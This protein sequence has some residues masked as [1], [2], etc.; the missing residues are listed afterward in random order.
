M[1]SLLFL[2][3]F[4][5]FIWW[6]LKKTSN[7]PNDA[8]DTNSN[9]YMHGY[10]DGYQARQTELDKGEKDPK[11][12]GMPDKMR[13]IPTAAILNMAESHQQ[14]VQYRPPV[15]NVT[16]PHITPH[17]VASTHVATPQVV[18]HSAAPVKSS[19]DQAAEKKKRDLQNINTTLYVASFLLVAA[20]A[21]FVAVADISASIRF[22]G[23]W[24][25]TIAFYSAGLI[26][27]GTVPRLRPAAI[28]FA[29][30]GLAL[31]PFTG[32]AMYNFILPNAPLSWFVTSLISLAAFI[33]A[34]TRLKNEV[35]SYL[36][37]AFGISLST[38]G[39]AVLD[40][41]LIWYYVVL[42]L[43]GS[44]LTI[45][46][47]AR[48]K[49][50]PDYFASPIQK[51]NHWIV[52]LTIISSIF[53]VNSLTVTD[54]WIIS[55]A[56]TLYY[57]AVAA[58][59]TTTRDI[60]IFVVRL[61]ASLTVILMAYDLSD[62]SWTV[63]GL[64]IAFVGLLQTLV[65]ILF[66]PH[67]KA[68]E[69]NNEIWL[70]IGFGMQ[71]LSVLFI[72]NDSSWNTVVSIQ[73]SMMLASSLGIAYWL[74]RINLS[75]FGTISLVSLPVI[76]ER[77]I[78]QPPLENQW[79]ALTFIAF[80]A[81]LLAI[82]YAKQII[83]KSPSLI[84]YIFVN[85]S[86]FI[87][88][89]LLFTSGNISAGWGFTIWSVATLLVYGLMYIES[90]PWLSIVANGMIWVSIVNFI[91]PSVDAQWVA[92]IF[93][94]LASIALVLLY[95]DKYIEDSKKAI[96]RPFIVAN[97]TLF[98][99]QSLIFTVGIP[100]GWGFAIWSVA[101]LLVYGLMYLERQPWLSIVANG[102]IFVSI[103]TYIKPDLASH[104]IAFIFITLATITF[105]LLVYEKQ[106]KSSIIIRPYII[107]N[108]VLFIAQSL[109]FTIN[110]PAGWGF[111]I[112]SVA[113]VL[114]YGLM[115]LER[116][117]WLSIV[118][119]GMIWFSIVSFIKPSIDD[120]WVALIFIILASIALGILYLEKYIEDSKKATFRPF[121]VANI[122]L[123]II[124]SLMFTVS[125][126]AIWGLA[127]WSI[128][129]A[130]VYGVMYLESKPWVS[131]VA[132][133]MI[134][135]LVMQFVRPSI[136]FHWLAVIFI[137]LATIAFGILSVEK[138]IN[139]NKDLGIRQYI[140]AN[141]A[142]F[143][144][145]S[146]MFTIGIESGWGLAVWTVATAIVYGV[147]Y[148][149]RQPWL[150]ILAN[151][152]IWIAVTQFIQP[153]VEVYWV[154]LIFMT[155]SAISLGLLSLEKLIF[156]NAPSSTRQSIVVNFLLF[157]F[158]SLFLTYGMDHNWG[159]GLW[160]VAT[161]FAYI[162]VYL[163][164]Q[165]WLILI[166][167]GMLLVSTSRLLNIMDIATEWKS[168]AISWVAF[169]VFY[170]IYWILKLLSQDK[171]AVYQWWSAVVVAGLINILSLTAQSHDVAIMAG[172]GL[173]I[174][175]LAII[176]EGFVAH[177]Y[178]Y[179][180]IGSILA[181]IGLQRVLFMI[182]PDTNILVYTHWW[183]AV[184][185]LVS[186]AYYS[187][188]KV[189]SAKFR[190]NIALTF[191]SLFG[192]LAALGFF[193][194]SDVPYQV[195]FLIEHALILAVGLLF[196]RKSFTTWGAVGVVL[197]VVW[198]IKDMTYLLLALA[199]LGLIGFAVYAL[200]KQSKNAK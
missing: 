24:L 128:A 36:A 199:A 200:N 189:T 41:G 178:H 195:I 26:L 50:L 137:V 131:I 1:G 119:N 7:G 139:T 143:I 140:L 88:E 85:F 74:R 152:M 113:T 144:I 31:L 122:V 80:A 135:T 168:L 27:H 190:G 198:M 167:N 149:E 92:L 175:S 93:I 172:W 13:A 116:Q 28:A 78:F 158:Q 42:I 12:S 94:V 37:I 87:I 148:L 75:I 38:S 197:S 79:I 118:A 187:D 157:T 82:R 3:A 120:H 181:T 68:G 127:I 176:V 196:S 97:V 145:E 25:V 99:I 100:A 10:W 71:M 17:V 63:V 83:V 106:I 117:P 171:Y 138:Y 86:L 43:F 18:I 98:I 73:L 182:A 125:I 35:L 44:V 4:I 39:I 67:H 160:S 133:G 60:S 48:P 89:A 15:E 179:I 72:P 64:A 34:A 124:Q 109:L 188:G 54:F 108:L 19:A 55:L 155:L 45:L 77:N 49:W 193:G 150:S 62:A 53:G 101:T 161:L 56:S 20:A 191:I 84:P 30:T 126:E 112:W 141:I 95:V 61:L 47:T 159:F 11:Y 69:D 23:V 90:Q 52:P 186:F 22:I 163:E 66:L 2:I 132:N 154:G 184:I 58:T 121:I 104:W 21:L 51:T 105:E 177:K 194:A 33:L 5:W 123:F 146:L 164:S 57:S 46:A 16:P 110:V 169:G 180:D 91:K 65:S 130:I 59:S 173:A 70:W 192:G 136:E 111:A 29:G 162:F 153:S 185:A 174:V 170:A 134:L 76:V 40:A 147:M 102:M 103:V 183:A 114:I 96:F 107:A 32:I 165:P 151:A 9:D 166:A 6:I 129:T 14:K 81:T 142:I 115:Y 156:A 8:V